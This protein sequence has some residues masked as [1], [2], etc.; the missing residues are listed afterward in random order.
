M[1]KLIT[2]LETITR[3]T[4]RDE[5]RNVEFRTFIKCLGWEDEKLD[6]LVHEILQSVESQ[7]DCTKCANC[8]RVMQT[9]V[10]PEDID[11]LAERLGISHQEF[12]DQYKAE[13]NYWG[14]TVIPEMPCPFLDDCVCTVYDARPSNCRDYPHIQKDGFRSRMLSVLGNAEV[15]PIVFNVLEQLKEQF[16]WQSRSRRAR[17]HTR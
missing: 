11:R 8:C 9:A 1:A 3:V 17:R 2:D 13:E 6:A 14:D 12:E 10:E 5:D 16:G 15:C 7:I 4:Q